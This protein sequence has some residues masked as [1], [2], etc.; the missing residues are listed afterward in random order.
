MAWLKL[1]WAII[2][3][4]AKY[5]KKFADWV[6]SHKSQIMKWSSAGWTVAE[7]VREIARILGLG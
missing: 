7:I 5:G 4:G 2:K 6:W 1:A 3:A